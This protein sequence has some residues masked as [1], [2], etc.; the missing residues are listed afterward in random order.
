VAST[1][2]KAFNEF[3]AL[4]KPTSGEEATITSRR[5]AVSNFMLKKYGPNSTMQLL[6]TKVIGSAARSTLVRPISDIDIFCV[7]ASAQV[8]QR[9]KNDSQQLLYRVRE[10]LT[11]YQVKTVG[12]RG[13]AVR[14]FYSTGPNVDITPAFYEHD[15][16]GRPTGGYLI[17]RGDGK[18]QGTNPYAHTD[19]MARRNQEL[20]GYL[21]P[22]VRLLK[23][24]NQAHSAHLKS[25]HLEL[26]A[27][28]SFG[29]LGGSMRNATHS[30]FEWSPN[31][32]HV[33]DPAGY[34]GD[35]AA[36]LTR[37]RIQN[38]KNALAGGAEHAKRAQEAE[39][40][41]RISEAM[42]QWGIVFGSGFPGY[43]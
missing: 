6:E 42:Q 30:F 9:Y 1:V 24:W 33:H 23:R 3:S 40:A 41:G 5:N 22:L 36:A 19:F 10:A 31:Y 18:W 26:L 35:L 12:S 27:Q 25:F 20:G 7:F 16:F 34:S 37:D 15:L 4:I 13:Q 28:A 17:P 38:I 14:L 32:L 29:S 11:G 8:W 2:P 39:A 43:G 21:K